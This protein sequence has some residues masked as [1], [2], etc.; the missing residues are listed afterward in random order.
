MLFKN[1]LLFQLNEQVTIE[2]NR[3]MIY[4]RYILVEYTEIY[5]NQTYVADPELRM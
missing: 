1:V 4:I 2:S 3:T 5:R